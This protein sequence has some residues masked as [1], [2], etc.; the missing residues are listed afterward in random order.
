ML[1]TIATY[2][3]LSLPGVLTGL[4]LMKWFKQARESKQSSERVRATVKKR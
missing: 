2:W 1:A 3:F 4:L